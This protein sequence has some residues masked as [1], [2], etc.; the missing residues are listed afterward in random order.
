MIAYVIFATH[1]RKL[2]LYVA[3]VGPFVVYTPLYITE[4]E[5]KN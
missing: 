2:Y 3:K 5:R 1:G 4:S